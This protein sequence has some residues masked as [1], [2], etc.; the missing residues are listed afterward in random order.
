MGENDLLK[1][2]AQMVSTWIQI[3]RACWKF[4][5]TSI[6]LTR[7]IIML[8]EMESL[9]YGNCSTPRFDSLENS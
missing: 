7:D 4:G 6:L 8:M 9:S 3:A 5:Y 1:A 2:E